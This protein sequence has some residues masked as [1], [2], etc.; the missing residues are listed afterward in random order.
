M[1][2]H[3]ITCSTCQ[4]QFKTDHRRKYC[5]KECR[6]SVTPPAKKIADAACRQVHECIVCRISFTPKRAGMT[7]CCSRECGLQ[8]SSF[9]RVAY[10]NGGRVFVRLKMTGRDQTREMQGPPSPTGSCAHCGNNYIR[11]KLWQRYCCDQCSNQAKSD[12][13]QSET[14]RAGRRAMRLKRKAMERGASV[15]YSIDPIKVFE[16]DAWRCGLCGCKTQQSKRGTTH[17]K[18]PELDH[19]IALANGGRH[20]WDNVQCSCRQC[21]GRKGARDYGQIPMHFG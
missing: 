10:V 20:T 2:K 1:A 21:N 5:T 7:K 9:K 14:Y 15:G 16:R 8:W 4:E 11:S 6:P 17:P 13:K 12:V 18:A 3:C 19:I